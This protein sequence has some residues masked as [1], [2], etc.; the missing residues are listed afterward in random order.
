MRQS[1][2]SFASAK[3]L[4]ERHAQELIAAREILDVAITLV[5]QHQSLK[6]LPRQELHQLSEHELA[7]SHAR[8]REWK[9]PQIRALRYSNRGHLRNVTSQ[10]S[11]N[12]LHTASLSFTGHYWALTP[13]FNRG[14]SLNYQ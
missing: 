13:I 10:R 4:G 14:L 11:I 6:S 3:V 7:R 1:R 12:N 9:S 5:L 8:S 2:N